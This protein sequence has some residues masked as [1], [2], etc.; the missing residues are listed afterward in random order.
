MI[1]HVQDIII[2]YL[3]GRFPVDALPTRLPDAWELDEDG[4]AE[5]RELTLQAIGYLAEYERGDRDE[6][7]LR[8]ALMRLLLPDSPE[9]SLGGSRTEVREIAE[10]LVS[11]RLGG[12]PLL[13]VSC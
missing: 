10:P 2:E 6:A 13:G 8:T 5:A 9:T 7:A 1:D 11:T 4:N 12:K 3:A